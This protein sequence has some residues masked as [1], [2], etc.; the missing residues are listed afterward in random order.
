MENGLTCIVTC[1]HDGRTSKI[2]ELEN[3]NNRFDLGL[4]TGQ[5]KWERK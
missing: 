4:G 3:C 5:T 1:V 2:N